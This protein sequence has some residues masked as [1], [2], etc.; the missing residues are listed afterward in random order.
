M[1]VVAIERS[2]SNEIFF[3]CGAKCKLMTFKDIIF[4]FLICLTKKYFSRE[5]GSGKLIS[6]NNPSSPHDLLEPSSWRYVKN[7]L[8]ETEYI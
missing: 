7:F 6:M 8:S 3:D 5:R 4:F 2:C 1:V